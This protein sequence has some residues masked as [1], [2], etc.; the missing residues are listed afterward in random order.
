MYIRY[1]RSLAAVRCRFSWLGQKVKDYDLGVIIVSQHCVC[2]RQ[3]F[4]IQLFSKAIQKLLLARNI[5]LTYEF[6]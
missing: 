6:I 4:G 3:T 1:V 2:L 5:F